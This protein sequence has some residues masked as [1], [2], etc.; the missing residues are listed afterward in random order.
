MLT[1]NN[2]NCWNGQRSRYDPRKVFPF[3]TSSDEQ[4]NIVVAAY[5]PL[6]NNIYNLPRAVDDPT[7][8]NLAKDMNK[9]PAQLLVSWA[10]QRGT[11]VLP[12]SVTPSRI[13]DNFQ[14]IF[15][16]FHGFQTRFNLIIDFELPQEV[17]DK[18]TALD[19]HHRYNFPA[20]LGVDIF[21]EVSEE[22]LKKSVEDWKA[23]QRK[24]K[25]SS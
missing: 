8:V 13:A 21:G 1:C 15:Q 12:K 20:R 10:V 14:G 11:V 23:A 17:F 19:R 16:N 7:V 18:I 24:L 25:A 4:Q 5:S 3:R 22:S 6:G 2:Q 9:Q